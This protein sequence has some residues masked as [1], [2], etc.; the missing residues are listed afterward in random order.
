MNR[1]TRLAILTGLAV[2]AATPAP[3]IDTLLAFDGV[4]SGSPANSAALAGVTFEPAYYAP[5]LDPNGNPVPGSEAW[6]IDGSAPPVT[7][8]DPAGFGRGSAPS[9]RNALN[10]LLQPVLVQFV[11][12]QSIRQFSVTL[13]QDP[14]GQRGLAIGFYDGSN[15]L[16]GELAIDQTVPGFSL[17]RSDLDLAGVDRIVLPAGAFYD[18]VAVSSIPEPDPLALA[19]VGFACLLASRRRR[20]WADCPQVPVGGRPALRP[21]RMSSASPE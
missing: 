11:S 7:V 21:C 2:A 8:D 16:L 19:I 14:Y 6:R 1:L 17:S 18:N 5:A 20:S 10:A 15:R 3:A 13:D 4:P 12:P 9:P